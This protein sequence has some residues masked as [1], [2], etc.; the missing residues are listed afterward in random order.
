MVQSLILSLPSIEHLAP[1][2]PIL[3]RLDPT[4]VS[5]IIGSDDSA[6]DGSSLDDPPAHPPT[7]HRLPSLASLDFAASWTR[8]EQV[9]ALGPGS[10]LLSPGGVTRLAFGDCLRRNARLNDETTE[11]VTK[12]QFQVDD[13]FVESE[14]VHEEHL[15]KLLG[16]DPTRSEEADGFMLIAR[17]R[18]KA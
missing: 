1:W 11:V 6:S 12:L 16:P 7:I 14:T 3:S 9:N 5:L 13:E 2:S 18:C 4:S 15:E 17:I 8:L 10:V